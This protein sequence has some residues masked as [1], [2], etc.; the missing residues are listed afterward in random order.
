[1]LNFWVALLV[2]I[3]SHAAISRTSLRPW[4]A[5]RLGEGG[6]ILSYSALSVVLLGWLLKAAQGAPRVALWPW[7]HALYWVPNILMPLAFVL[8]VS[9]FV[10]ANP[11]SIA[12]RAEGFDPARP[13][14][15]VALTRHPVLWGFFLWAVSHVV[16]NGEFPLALMF[17]VFAAFA[18]LGI[19]LIDRKRKRILGTAAWGDLARATHPVIFCSGALWRGQFRL[20][21]RDVMGI[22]GGLALYAA[23]YML[24]G[25]FFGID[26]TPPL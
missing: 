4:L 3:G 16:V 8:L 22:M 19:I 7:E 23:F 18:L 11:L 1:M 2:F 14:L 13:G 6:Y 20:T 26:P 12:P 24:H 21:R 5:A 9:G 25:L 10:V 15:I 17:G